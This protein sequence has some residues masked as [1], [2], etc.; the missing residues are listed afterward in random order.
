MDRLL[1]NDL[2]SA[3]NTEEIR[4]ITHYTNGVLYQILN[5]NG[6]LEKFVDT[7]SSIK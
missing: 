2:K 5:N 6:Y 3:C 4:Y 7:T 1:L